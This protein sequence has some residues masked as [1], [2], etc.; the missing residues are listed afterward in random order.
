MNAM[1]VQEPSIGKL[2]RFRW[3]QASCRRDVYN[4]KGSE[5][6]DLGSS[7]VVQVDAAIHIQ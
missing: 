3:N 1:L 7:L 4:R 2:R 6:L 5:L